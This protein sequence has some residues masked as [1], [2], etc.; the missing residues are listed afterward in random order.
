MQLANL[1]PVIPRREEGAGRADRDVRL[2][3]RTGRGIAVQLERRA[4][5]HTTVGGADIIDVARI[6]AGAVLGI[7]QVN[8]VV[9]GGRLTPA[10][11]SPVAAGYP[12][13]MQAK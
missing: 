13:N 7:D 4:K 1:A 3:L 9:V 10:L 6:S 12:V 11:V 5:G 2:P 8:H